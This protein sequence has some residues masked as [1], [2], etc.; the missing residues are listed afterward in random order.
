MNKKLIGIVAVILSLVAILFYRLITWE[1][2][3]PDK[4]GLGCCL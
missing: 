4:V 1:S 2:P 3:D